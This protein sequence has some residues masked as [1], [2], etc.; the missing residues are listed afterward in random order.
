MSSDLV[1][2][3]TSAQ[4]LERLADIARRL[5][6]AASA[7]ALEEVARLDHEL[8]CAA[9]AVV[10][11]IPQGEAPL[12]EQLESVRDALRAVEVAISS[13]KVQQK[14]LKQKIDQS[15]RLRLAYKRKD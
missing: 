12:V 15:R 8:R 3:M 6:K 11:T 2:H 7:G 4:S 10:G 13:V 9:L 5:E 14:Q 1:R